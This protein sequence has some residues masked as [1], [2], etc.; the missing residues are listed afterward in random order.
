[1]TNFVN[2]KLMVL[3]IMSFFIL[4]PSVYANKASKEVK[5]AA[6]KVVGAVERQ[7]QSHAIGIGL[8][9]TFLFGDFN[10]NGDEKITT[11]F[12]YSYAASYSFDLL[13][14]AH[15]STHS[16]QEREL[17][18]RGVAI[19]IK[20]RSFEYDAFSPFVLGGL[21]FYQPQYSD[22]DKVSDQKQTF[23]FNAG[24]GV[25]LRLNDKIV[26]GVLGQ[27]HNPF[28]IKQDNMTNV[29]GSYFKLLLTA[30]YLL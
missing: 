27:Y 14:N 2:K 8:G 19:S 11:D 7:V 5:K 26:I 30:M 4:S 22:G 18:L 6:S 12:F 20:G 15:F 16:Y 29:R 1:M 21:G 25:D 28:E 10:N 17:W 3:A 13:L 23:G 24:A 9:Q